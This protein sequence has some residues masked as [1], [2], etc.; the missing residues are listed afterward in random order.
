MQTLRTVLDLQAP[1]HPCWALRSR[2][3][4]S[5]QSPDRPS[6]HRLCPL[7]WLSSPCPLVPLL[8]PCSVSTLSSHPRVLVSAPLLSHS[9]LSLLAILRHFMVSAH[10]GSVHRTQM[11]NL[12]LRAGLCPEHQ[13]SCPPA[14]QHLSQTSHTRTPRSSKLH[15]H[16]QG[17]K[18]ADGGL[19]QGQLRVSPVRCHGT[20]IPNPRGGYDAVHL[21]SGEDTPQKADGTRALS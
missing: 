15:W 20:L 8:P 21:T 18:T 10:S 9:T 19:A 13:H 3:P 4:A 5:L 14:H 11:A 12:P 7:S 17:S 2:S 16:C 1:G 6:S